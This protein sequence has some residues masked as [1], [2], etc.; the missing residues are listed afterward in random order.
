MR[1][2]LVDTGLWKEPQPLEPAK[3]K[4]KSRAYALPRGT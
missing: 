1:E 2:I 4:R 3:P